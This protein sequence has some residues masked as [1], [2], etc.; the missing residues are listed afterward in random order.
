VQGDQPVRDRR[1]ARTNPLRTRPVQVGEQ[2]VDH[3]IA[4][5]VDDV[6]PVALP[7]QVVDGVRGRCEQEVAES[8]G[9]DPVHLLRHGP[10]AAAQAGLDVRDQRTG[11]GGHE[12]TRDG[13]VD[14]PDDDDDVRLHL[15]HDWFEGRHDPRRLHGVAGR[16]DPQRPIGGPDASSSKKTWLM[17]AS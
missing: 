15:L 10:V 7:S 11:L 5:E 13:G 9:D 1:V 12:R 17:A 14:V 8:V 3:D 6:L 4:D 16:A 2:A